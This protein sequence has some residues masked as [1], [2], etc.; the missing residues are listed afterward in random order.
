MKSSIITSY[1][2]LK[3]NWEQDESEDYLDNFTLLIAEAIKHLSSDIITLST[4]QKK[5]DD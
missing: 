2:I 5:I 1:A 4:L 3:E